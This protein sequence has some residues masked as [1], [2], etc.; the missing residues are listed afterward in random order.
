MSRYSQLYIDQAVPLPDS[1]RARHRLGK[2]MEN[3][4]SHTPNLS[5]YIERELGIEVGALH[6]FDWPNFTTKCAM[7][8]LL[9]T[10]T[11]TFR[12]LT[13]SGRDVRWLSETRRI[14]SEERLAYEIDDKAVVHPAVDRE[15]QRN[16]QATVAGLQAPRYANSLAAFERISDELASDPPNG[17]DAW[18]AAFGA[19][20]GLFR[21]MFCSAPQLNAGAVETHLAPLVQKLYGTDAVALRAANKQVASFKDW[22]DASHNYRHEQSS[23]E[24]VQPPIDLAVLAISN[25]T[26]FLRWLIALDQMTSPKV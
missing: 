3:S 1:A 15:F 24:P 17:K 4:V 2:L 13:G 11:L 18:R 7:R 10:V 20:E 8:D 5:N 25:G 21:L 26:S 22:V 6:S 19:V 23:E 14:F 16:R 9:D 12:H